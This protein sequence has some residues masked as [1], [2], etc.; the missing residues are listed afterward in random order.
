MPNREDSLN[1]AAI[2]Y[3][4]VKVPLERV[5]RAVEAQELALG[6]EKT[7]W[8]ATS[9]DDSGRAA[10]FHAVSTR[11]SVVIIAG[12]DGTVRTVTE[13]VVDSGIPIA[14]LPFGTGNLLARNLGLPLTNIGASVRTAF[15]LTTR[16]VDTAIA[17]FEDEDG[18]RSAHR[19][20]VMAGIGLDA[21]MAT[22][23]N[24]LVKKHL[25]WFA[26]VSPIARS[27]FANRLFTM[28]Y[29]VDD[30]PAKS[31]HA[32]T[33]IVGNCGTLTGNMLLLPG[34]VVDDGQLDVIVFRPKNWFGWTKIG[35][36]LT[37]Q[38]IA[39]LS[40]FGRSLVQFNGDIQA[41]PYGKGAAF[42]ARFEVPHVVQLDGDSFGHIISARI[43]VRPS[44]L[45]VCVDG[46]K[47]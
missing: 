35:T 17:E 38:G 7:R 18:A 47:G 8:Y 27:I 16:R 12:G 3:N 37:T 4:P 6:W 46:S 2:V 23:T 42:E 22:N 11:P 14:L 41:L 26:Y 36:R 24:A 9:S 33:V 44:T 31:T 15:A 45:E 29:R 10:A 34:A 32:H 1:H 39:N 40:R 30:G 25:G 43:S 21:E 28:H 13:A 19:F 20:L 5:R